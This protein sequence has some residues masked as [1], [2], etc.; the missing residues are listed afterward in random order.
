M[1]RDRIWDLG[2]AF[3]VGV[4]VCFLAAGVAVARID[5]LRTAERAESDAAWA[6]LVDLSYEQ[7][8]QTGQTMASLS[9]ATLPSGIPDR[10][11]SL[12]AEVPHAHL[13]LSLHQLRHR[14]RH[15]AEDER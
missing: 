12:V 5:W 2:N 7:G 1:D 4:A 6:H 9:A 10:V 3:A 13:R 8:Y 14:K 11:P 15:H